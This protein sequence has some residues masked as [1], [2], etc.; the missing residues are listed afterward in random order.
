MSMERLWVKGFRHRARTISNFGLPCEL[1]AA[2]I[3]RI[4][5]G[6]LAEHGCYPRR[7]ATQKQIKEWSA[8]VSAHV[9]DL[10]EWP[11][12]NRYVALS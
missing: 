6:V 8:N 4:E 11:I 2:D 9:R 3:V 10:C 5:D 12:K 1:D 7:K